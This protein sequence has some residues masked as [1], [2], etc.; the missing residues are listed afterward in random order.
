MHYTVH[1]CGDVAKNGKTPLKKVLDKASVARLI[2]L[3]EK[4]R[5]HGLFEKGSKAF[6]E[7]GNTRKT[8]KEVSCK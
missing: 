6:V 5:S 7:V 3:K 4:F 1:T 8:M 2:Y